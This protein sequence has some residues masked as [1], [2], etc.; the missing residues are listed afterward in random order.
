MHRHTCPCNVCRD[1][2][3]GR[4]DDGQRRQDGR[5]HSR[6][7]QDRPGRGLRRYDGASRYDR[8]DWH[9]REPPR[10]VRSASRASLR[11][12]GFDQGHDRYHRSDREHEGQGRD[13]RAVR[14]SGT[15]PRP[16]RSRSRPPTYDEAVEYEHRR[17]QSTPTAQGFPYVSQEEGGQGVG[18]SSL[19]DRLHVVEGR[20]QVA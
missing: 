19:L 18:H 6:S 2:D 15:S 8:P 16:A 13:R 5:G 11:G 3:Q 10:P 17:P 4:D 7:G 1:H 9:D 12:P 14:V 20:Q